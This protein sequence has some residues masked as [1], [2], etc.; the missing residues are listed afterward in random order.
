MSIVAVKQ[1]FEGFNG[2]SEKVNRNVWSWRLLNNSL[3]SIISNLK[4]GSCGFLLILSILNERVMIFVPKF[5]LHILNYQRA[6]AKIIQVGKV[7]LP[8]QT[9]YKFFCIVFICFLYCAFHRDFYLHWIPK[10]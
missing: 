8:R 1:T 6:T 10:R 5:V 2:Q 7:V 4:Q 3:K 9:W